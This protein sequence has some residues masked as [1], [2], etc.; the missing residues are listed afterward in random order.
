MQRFWYIIYNIFIVPLLLVV[1]NILA[2]FNPKVKNGIDTRKRLK[3]DLSEKISKLDRTKKLVW[4]HSASMGEFEQAKPII[5]KIR[6]EKD[7]NIIV[8]FFSPSGYENSK[9]YPYADIIT[10]LPFDSPKNIREFIELTNPNLVILM[11]YDIWPNM[12]WQLREREIPCM[13]VDATMR[14]TSKRKMFGA[15][16]FHKIIF[17]NFSKILTISEDDR[18]NFLDFDIESERIAAV[19]DTR[20]DRVYQK[21]L[22]AKDKKLFPDNF[23]AGKKVFVA[24]SSWEADEEVIL[25]AFLK[26]TQNDDKAVLIL[27]PHEPTV[28]HIE[29]LENTLVGQ[30][31]SIRFSLLNNYDNE[32]VIIVDSIGILLTLYYYADVAYV[33]GSF[34][35]GI[36]NVLEPAV[37][38]I[39]V[40]YGPKIEGSREAGILSENNG[41][42]IVKEK[43][44]AYIIFRKLL[45]NEEERREFGERSFKFVQKNIGATDKIV[46]EIYNYI[47][48]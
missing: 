20:F 43:R 27:V 6:S 34:K 35:Q 45:S 44:E 4:F 31:R 19:G 22:V 1:F 47:S 48:K 38:G 11:R 21:S 12:I 24:G 39:P 9:K 5:E 33:G 42:F 16:S 7:V 23:F 14:K 32:R 36:H 41:G 10:Y 37:Y 13:I 8:T 25:P 30:E 3:K 40:V 29:K 17:K 2:V 26:L 46:K 18:K 28:Q 15:K